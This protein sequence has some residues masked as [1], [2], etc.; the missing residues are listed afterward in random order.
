MRKFDR[1]EGSTPDM[2]RYCLFS[3]WERIGST[4]ASGIPKLMMSE[5]QNFPELAVF[6]Q[7]EVIQPGNDA[8]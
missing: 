1:F 3:W 7:Q 5:A 4:K 8:D 2:L 6:Y